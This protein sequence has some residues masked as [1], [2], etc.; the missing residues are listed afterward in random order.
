[1]F[2]NVASQKLTVLVIDT[3]ANTPKTGDAAN[4]T[5]YVSK[6][7]GAVTVLGDT[8]ATELDATNAPGLYSFDLTQAETNADKLLFSGKS[9]TSGIRVIPLL[10]Y[11]APASFTSFTTPPTAAQNASAVWQDTTAGDFTVAL[12]VGKSLMNGVSLG[13]GLT[14]ARCTLTDTLTTYTGNTPQTGDAFARIGATGS[15]LTSLAPAATA[16]TSATWTNARAAALDNLDAAVSSRSTFA[17]GAVAS[18]TGDVGGKLLGGG[19]GAI[20]GTGARADVRAW[21]GQTGG[22]ALSPNNVPLVSIYSLFDAGN[23]EV[24]VQT[25]GAT[26]LTVAFLDA[27]VS[28]TATAAALATLQ[29]TATAINTKTTNLPAAPAAVGDI[30]TTAQIADKYLDRSLAGGV[31]AVGTNARSVRNALRAVRNKVAFD[32][33][34][35]G[36]FTVYAEDD[37]TVAYTGTYSRS[38]TADNPL[39]GVDPV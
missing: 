9:S 33:P 30:P 1:M 7:D 17:G 34:V 10:L 2:K 21:A 23:G 36:Q 4:L 11:T 12:S 28:G 24:A 22:V 5:C 20:T 35:A 18:V 38:A 6:D 29:T 39:T 32:V 14:V 37:V 3:A 13:T 8:T 15:G 26:P 27:P 25:D 31:D 16:L 19:V